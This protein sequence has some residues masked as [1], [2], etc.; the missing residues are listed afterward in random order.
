MTQTTT[1][2]RRGMTEQAAGIAIDQACRM[3]RLPSVR[4]HFDD[5][6]DTAARQQQS[7]R[8]FLAELLL[9]ECDDRA[10]RRSERRIKAAGFPR[11]K[12]LRAFDYDANQAV[13]PAVINTLAGCDWVRKGQPLCLVG[14]SGTGKSHLLIALVDA[15]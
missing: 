4:T 3:L 10:R 6:A 12:S 1:P 9:V 7:Y 15:D 8:A 11:E 14:D 2:P 13:D 5:V